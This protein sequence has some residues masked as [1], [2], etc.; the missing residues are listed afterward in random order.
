MA[1]VSSTG[2][3][4]GWGGSK[5]HKESTR[6]GWDMTREETWHKPANPDTD[7]IT[8]Q[9]AVLTNCTNRHI[10]GVNSRLYFFSVDKSFVE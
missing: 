6:K 3:A 10:N 5:V 1:A 8:E 9:K 7:E 2:S 4:G